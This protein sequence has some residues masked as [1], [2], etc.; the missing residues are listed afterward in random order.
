[1]MNDP[2]GCP[3][4]RI[5]LMT[6]GSPGHLNDAHRSLPAEQ[7]ARLAALPGAASLHPDDTGA[8]DMTETADLIAGL[9]LVISVDT[10]VAHL[11]GAM[12]KPTWI[13]L[14]TIGLDWRWGLA[15]RR[16]A[17]YPQARL[18]RQPRIND[19]PGVV[20]AVLAAATQALAGRTDW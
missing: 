12:G 11:A 4:A 8:G 3:G 6:R 15:G 19:W 7:A 16:T 2:C 20:D 5:G 18:F 14:P 9:D 10:S 17:W 1:M 13:L